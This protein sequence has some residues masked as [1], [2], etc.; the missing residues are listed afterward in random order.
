MPVEPS[1]SIPHSKP[2]LGA[3]E[4][5][6]AHRVVLSGMLAEG[7]ETRALETELQRCWDV[8]E[9]AS[10][11]HGTAGLHL[12]LLG[13]GVG[14]GQK[15]LL[16]TYSCISLLNAV[17]YTGAEAVLV[18]SEAGGFQMDTALAAHLA[19]EDGSI[20]AAI[21]PHLFG[22]VA[23]VEPLARLVQV[24][25]D[26][27]H[28]VGHSKR[29]Q[30]AAQIASFFATK[31]LAGGEGGAVGSNDSALME[32]VRDLRS[33]DER[34]SWVPRFNYKTTDL[35]AA[36]LRVQ[37]SRLPEFL[38]ARRALAQFYREQ[39]ADVPG[40]ALPGAQ[41][42]EVHYRFPVLVQGGADRAIAHLQAAG[43]GA[44]RPV[45]RLI[46][47]YLDRPDTPYP[48]AV[49]WWTSCVSLP[50]YPALAEGE[51]L[52]VTRAV[53]NLRHAD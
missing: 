38:R 15:V 21:V 29:L 27:T 7:A 44:R 12:A 17:A 25:E 46:H 48:E 18:D 52:R 23:N 41:P 10:V 32:V 9:A 3:D 6:A 28:S 11:A 31:M 40:V 8:A 47:Q 53:Q 42:G 39:L 45:F 49:R 20:T 50:I 26:C 4:A 33:Y 30:G 36:I 37:L 2:L 51:A 5:N 14:A 16:P 34:P 35:T 24:V 1:V 43:V 13:L 19:S 22:Q